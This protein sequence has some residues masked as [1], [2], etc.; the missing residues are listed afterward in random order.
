MFF[1]HMTIP[2]IAVSAF[3]PVAVWTPGGAGIIFAQSWNFELK[4]ILDIPL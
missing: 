3:F 2:D 1:I 4:F